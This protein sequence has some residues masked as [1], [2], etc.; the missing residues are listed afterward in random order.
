MKIEQKYCKN[1]VL[2]HEETNHCVSAKFCI[3]F[4][5]STEFV[6]KKKTIICVPHV[7]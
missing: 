3:I 4:D 6:Q 5:L 2:C 1:L 7:F